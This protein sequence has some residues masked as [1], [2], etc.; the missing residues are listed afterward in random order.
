MQGGSK[1]NRCPLP[2]LRRQRSSLECFGARLSGVC[3]CDARG[4]GRCHV[5]GAVLEKVAP[6]IT[7]W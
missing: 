3:V 7:W 1:N 6:G 4:G 5:I 2:Q